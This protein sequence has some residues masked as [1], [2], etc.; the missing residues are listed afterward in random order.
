MFLI[1][2]DA[3][4]PCQAI[5]REN[6]ENSRR[7]WIRADRLKIQLYPDLIAKSLAMGEMTSDQTTF[8]FAFNE[9]KWNKKGKKEFRLLN[10]LCKETFF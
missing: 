7:T 3:C 1:I 2:T 9:S 8:E 4:Y 5:W 10:L 6:P